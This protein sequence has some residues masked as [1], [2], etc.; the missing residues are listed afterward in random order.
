[1]GNKPS[2]R[3]EVLE[4]CQ[5]SREGS[6]DQGSASRSSAI[7]PSCTVVLSRWRPRRSAGRTPDFSFREAL[8]AATLTT[9]TLMTPD[10]NRCLAPLPRW[11]RQGAA[12]EGVGRPAVA[13]DED[14]V[15]SEGNPRSR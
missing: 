5:P 8:G 13:F 12:T 6:G 15:L 9:L 10:P 2:G 4:R 14:A 11:D 7:S 1:M 3:G